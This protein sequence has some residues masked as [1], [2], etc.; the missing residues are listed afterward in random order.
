VLNILAVLAVAQIDR[1]RF[2]K[3]KRCACPR[4][5]VPRTAVGISAKNQRIGEALSAG[6]HDVAVDAQLRRLSRHRA[7]PV[8]AVLEELVRRA[9][10]KALAGMAPAE[11]QRYLRR[12]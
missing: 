4:T 12:L 2:S 7:L 1:S 3:S 5:A 11:E 9:E 6:S 8:A 10:Q